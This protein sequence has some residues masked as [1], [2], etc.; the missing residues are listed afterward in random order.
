MKCYPGVTTNPDCRRCG[1][2]GVKTGFSYPMVSLACPACGYEWRTL[3]ALCPRCRNSNET[4][5]M[6]DCPKC[7]RE[8][9]REYVQMHY[10]TPGKD[11]GD[12]AGRN[13]HNLASGDIIGSAL[14]NSGEVHH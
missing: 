10:E 4:P 14:F 7:K 2:R 8:E 5:I 12:H 6:G 13:Q 11:D 1:A 9:E 3:G